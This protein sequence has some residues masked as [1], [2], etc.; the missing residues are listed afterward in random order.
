MNFIIFKIPDFR[1]LLCKIGIHK[2]RFVDKVVRTGKMKKCEVCD[3]IKRDIFY[4]N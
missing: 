3:K 1:K 2:Y 4:Y